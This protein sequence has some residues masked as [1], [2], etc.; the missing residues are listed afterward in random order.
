MMRNSPWTFDPTTDTSTRA[1]ENTTMPSAARAARP[2]VPGR[3]AGSRD[4]AST[5][6][7]HA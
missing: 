4:D 1:G 7:A 2:I 3:F 6:P 5:G